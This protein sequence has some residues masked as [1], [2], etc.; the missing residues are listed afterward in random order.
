MK[1]NNKIKGC[2]FIL[3]IIA[4]VIAIPNSL[5]GFVTPVI[6]EKMNLSTYDDCND[7]SNMCI[8]R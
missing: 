4:S 6:S 1:K 8:Q 7:I 3:V 2:V 5:G